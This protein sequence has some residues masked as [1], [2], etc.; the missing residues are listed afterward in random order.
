MVEANYLFTQFEPR[1][2]LKTSQPDDKNAE[3]LVDTWSHYLKTLHEAIAESNTAKQIAQ[4]DYEKVQALAI[5][6]EQKMQI[7]L[8][9]SSEDRVRQALAYKQIYTARA[10]QLKTLVERHTI[11]INTLQ[12]QLAFWE[13]QLLT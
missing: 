12:T 13:N 9:N 10:R 3:A 4:K 6:W 8:S 1:S 7:A 5:A 2:D 11:H